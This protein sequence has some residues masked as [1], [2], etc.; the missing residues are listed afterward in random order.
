MGYKE[1]TVAGLNVAF[2]NVPG[3]GITRVSIDGKD[4]FGFDPDSADF[5]QYLE[6]KQVQFTPDLPAFQASALR[7]ALTEHSEDRRRA[8][9]QGFAR[10]DVS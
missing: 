8:F 3:S 1:L 6:G 4:A 5:V 9:A 2:R 10:R 7:Q